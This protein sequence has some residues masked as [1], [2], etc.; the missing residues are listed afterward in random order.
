M[1]LAGWGTSCC[2]RG[3]MSDNIGDQDS[4]VCDPGN[5]SVCHPWGQHI[6]KSKYDR[7]WRWGHSYVYLP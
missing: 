2:F 1:I 6:N 3:H 4:A 5:Y 7:A